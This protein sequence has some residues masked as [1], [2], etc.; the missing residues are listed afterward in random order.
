MTRLAAALLFV[1]LLHP[2]FPG[3]QS[4]TVR[5]VISDSLGNRVPFA[6]VQ[7]DP[8]TR[9][10]ASD[11]GVVL[12]A[13][14]AADS[15][16]LSI[17]RIGFAPFDGWGKRTPDGSY[18]VR[19]AVLPQAIK[20]VQIRA[21]SENRLFR[22]GFYQRMEEWAKIT[23]RSAFITPEELEELNA[24]RVTS[25]LRRVDFLRIH[26]ENITGGAASYDMANIVRGR[27]RCTANILLDGQIPIGLAEEVFAEEV[28]GGNPV[29]RNVA[30]RSSAPVIPLDQVILPGSI[31]G[32]EVYQMASGA[33]VE[34]RTK[35]KRANCPLIAIW[36]G[37]RR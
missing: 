21:V 8:R 14:A 30:T 2:P 25:L 9:R 23:A 27:G 5:V 29:G 1:P 20:A 24:D 28:L 12:L 4:P 16:Q 15:I 31:A 33:P 22:S 11:S 18:E 32:L 34:L 17:R 19:L 7:V 13:R 3:S 26:R 35:V 36:S 6:V 37:A 10:A